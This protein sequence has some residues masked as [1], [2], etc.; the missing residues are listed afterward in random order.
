MRLLYGLSPLGECLCPSPPLDLRVGKMLLFTYTF[1]QSNL[2]L[3]HSS[4]SQ[5]LS[6][7]VL[8]G[9]SPLGECLARMPV[10][11]RVGKMLLFGALLGCV[12]PVLTIAAAMSLSRPPFLSPME[13]RA[14]VCFSLYVCVCVCVDIDIRIHTYRYICR[15]VTLSPALPIANGTASRGIYIYGFYI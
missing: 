3:K 12:D 6:V 13:Q 1:L 9:L 2:H 7:R 4:L 11:L 8:Y 5:A 15:N 14:E 10:D